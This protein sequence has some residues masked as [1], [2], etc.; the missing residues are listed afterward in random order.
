[1]SYFKNVDFSDP[2]RNI[3]FGNM[4]AWVVAWGA[5]LRGIRYT[6]A[7]R[8]YLAE[9]MLTTMH[10]SPINNVVELVKMTDIKNFDHVFFIPECEVLEFQAH[11][12]KLDDAKEEISRVIFGKESSTKSTACMADAL[13]SGSHE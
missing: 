11:R 9:N 6:L 2:E 5:H 3:M 7:Q 1:V 4:P 12:Q 13:A 10:R 8:Q